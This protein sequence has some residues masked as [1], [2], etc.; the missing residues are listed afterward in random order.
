MKKK[1]NEKQLVINWHVLEKCNFECKY[2]FA[3]WKDNGK[4]IWKSPELW[5]KMLRSVKQEIPRLINGE[6][7]SIRLNIAGGEPML[8]SKKLEDIFSF[9]IE[10]GYKLGM[11]SNG[12]LIENS[13][14]KKWAK[15][16]QIIGISADSFDTETNKK[17]GRCD[18][19]SNQISSEKIADIFKLFRKMN[20]DILCKLN[21]VVNSKNY[22]EKLHDHLKKINPDKWKIFQMHPIADKKEI[23]KKQEP[24]KISD[25]KYKLF[26]NNHSA[27]FSSIMYPENNDLMTESYIMIDPMGR[28][29]QNNSS[30]KH[31]YSD[32]ICKIGVPKAFEQIKFCEKKFEKRY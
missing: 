16:F 25:E 30:N 26:L 32:P 3:H 21:T 6:Y 20:P 24:L 29:Y 11:I 18:N 27:K 15:Y 9:A 23:S 1:E 10:I 31:N 12:Y 22:K 13:F 7:K 5:Q 8:L 2:C 17:I 19:N 4:E 14:I 28:F